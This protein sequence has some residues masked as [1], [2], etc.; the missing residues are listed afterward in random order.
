MNFLELCKALRREIGYSGSGPASVTSQTGESLRIVNWTLEAWEAIQR[1]R[2]DWR[3]MLR[4]FSLPFGAG[5]ASVLISNEARHLKRDSLVLFRADG[6]RSFPEEVTIEEMRTL[7]R[8]NPNAVSTVRFIALDDSGNAQ[9]YP[10]P[11]T[12]GTLHGEYH[13]K[14]V[15]MAENTDIPAMPE[16]YHMTIVWRALMAAAA[17]EGAQ[18]QYTTGQANYQEAFNWLTQEQ[19]PQMKMPGPLA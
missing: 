19:L 18:N 9:L 1:E 15:R 10:A 13:R 11:S 6:L 16:E 8:E 17:Y 2:T 14:P 12:S 5:A 4:E 7:R 3:F